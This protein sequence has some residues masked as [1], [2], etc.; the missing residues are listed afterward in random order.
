MQEKKKSK[1]PSFHHFGCAQK[2]QFNMIFKTYGQT[3]CMVNL[4]FVQY[5]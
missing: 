3:S 5:T 4:H 1:I 2:K